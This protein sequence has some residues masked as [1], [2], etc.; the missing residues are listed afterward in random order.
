MKISI[1]TVCYNSSK[2]IEKT[3]QSVLA[4]TYKNIEYIIVDGLSND[5][6]I[7]IIKKYKSKIT[8]IILEKDKGMYDALNKGFAISSGNIVG[9]LNAD[10]RFA[11]NDIIEKIANHFIQNKNTDCII[12]DIA[13]VDKNNP[14]KISR[15]YSSKNFKPSKFAWG[16][17]PAHPTFYCKT[18]YFNKLGG[19]KIEFDIASDYE[20]LIRFLKVHNLKFDYLNLLMV[21]MNKGGK[22]TSGLQSTFKI[23]NEIKSG[24]K[25][26]GVYTNYF[27]LYS[28]YLFKIFEYLK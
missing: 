8:K 25:M 4:Q 10:D 5:G 22:S 16:F 21:L 13:F 15:Y 26:N 11:A 12:G 19:Y 20:L 9:I 14:N 17:M 24:C 7:E 18:K 6:T 27:M 3:I 2:T 23:N 28:K 1:I